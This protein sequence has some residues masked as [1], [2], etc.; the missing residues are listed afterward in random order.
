[1]ELQVSHQGYHVDRHKMC[2]TAILVHTAVI[3][4]E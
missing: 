3:W 2:Q 4:E 1:M